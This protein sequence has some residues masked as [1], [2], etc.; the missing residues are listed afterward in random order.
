MAFEQGQPVPTFSPQPREGIDLNGPWRFQALAQD[1]EL[2]FGP[3]DSTA[4]GRLT[5]AAGQRLRDDFDDSAWSQ[6]EVPG[7]FTP[8][9][10][11]RTSGGWYRQ[12]FATPREWTGLATLK[13]ESVGY[14][15]DA[16]LNGR[17]LGYH[18]GAWTP[19]ALDASD[20]LRPGGINTLVLR[21]DDPPLGTRLDVVPWGLT[22]WW[23][24]GGITGSVRLEATPTLSIV[25][26][27]VT[28]H[29]DGMGISTV[30]QNRGSSQQDL[31]LITEVLPTVVTDANV[32]DPDPWHLV[33]ARSTAVVSQVTPLDPMP[34]GDVRRLSSSVVMRGADLWWPDLPAIYVLRVTVLGPA[35][36]LDQVYETFGL[37]QIKVDSSAPRLL[38]NGTAIAFHGVATHNER[39]QP[40]A[41]DAPAGGPLTGVVDAASLVQRAREV[42]ADFIR[43]DHHPA[44]PQLL[45]LADRLGF[46]VWEEIPLYHYT[47]ETFR[48]A[49]DRG[50]AQQMLAEMVLRDMNHPSVL[51]HGLANESTGGSERAAALINLRDLDRRLDGTRLTGQAAYG[52]DAEDTSSSDLDVAGYTLYSGVFY[53]GPLDGFTIGRTV[54][55]FHARYPHKPIMILEF[56]RWADSS[57]E[58]A[59]Q[60]RVFQVTYAELAQR[61][62]TLPNGFVGSA[63][64]W[65]LDDYWT[66]RPGLKIEH[67]GLHRPDG[68]LRPAG[69][70]ASQ[71]FAADSP[72]ARAAGGRIVT[73]GQGQFAGRPGAGRLLIGLLAYALALPA[74]SLAVVIF[75]LARGAPRRRLA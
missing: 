72:A 62:D 23:K 51:F 1:P 3:R 55:S 4:R 40:A 9:P 10:D 30:L 13:F 27:D 26:A 48:I 15:A 7:T 5:V 69:M 56:G 29:L 49:L 60:T 67:F 63:V 74:V 33:P 71:A 42:S 35:G 65:T 46:G 22:D 21:V 50:I 52:S 20:A 11:S 66:Q 37:R 64:W 8:P 31:V 44:S 58:E 18:E 2:T 61:F 59:E 36:L 43:A 19:F 41:G 14:V 73:G 47:P 12:R 38:L 45:A 16:W 39:V 75:L 25:R 17:Y 53:G 24:Y 68:S 32:R 6:V 28:P 34:G 57:G 70:V 54:E